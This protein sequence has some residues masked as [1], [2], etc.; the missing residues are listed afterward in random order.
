VQAET[1]GS[2]RSAAAVAG[3]IDHTLL[4]AF[5]PESDLRT[6]CAEA[7]EYRFASVMVHPCQIERC[8]AWL[9]GSG[10]PVGTVIGFPLGQNTTAVKE[11]EMRDALRRGARELDMVINLRALQAGDLGQVRAELEILAG[12]CRAAGAV[13]KAILETCYLTDA[14]KRRACEL[15]R[16]TGVQ[17]VKTST[18]FGSGGATVADIRLMRE[19]VGPAVGVKASG[20]IRDAA[21]ALAMIEAGANRLGTSSGVAI[22][23]ELL[24]RE[25]GDA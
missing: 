1:P 2:R 18:G 8:L 12:V 6:L 10:I 17:F 22:V 24:Q 9:Q 5:G 3:L 7:V 16:E 11:F 20:G 25:K 4:K 14:E 15:A 19:T 21:T 23:R 13:S